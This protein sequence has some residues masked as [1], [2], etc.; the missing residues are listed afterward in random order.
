M[1]DAETAN[2]RP[3]KGQPVRSAVS[4]G[5]NGCKGLSPTAAG[6]PLHTGKFRPPGWP[7]R[8]LASPCVKTGRVGWA[9]GEKDPDG[10]I[11]SLFRGSLVAGSAVACI[12]H[13]GVVLGPLVLLLSACHSFSFLILSLLLSVLVYKSPCLV[14]PAPPLL[15]ENHDVAS[16]QFAV[17]FFFSTAQHACSALLCAPP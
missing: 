17:N 14:E 9:S 1:A 4:G 7:I 8:R 12:Y 6:S 3:K 11:V 13:V 5:M 15:F 16:Q 10:A 2:P